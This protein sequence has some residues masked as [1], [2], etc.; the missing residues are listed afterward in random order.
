[1]ENEIRIRS[2]IE[3]SSKS[4]EI[5][6]VDVDCPANELED[7][8]LLTI[9]C[10]WEMCEIE[11]NKVDVWGWTDNTPEDQVEFRVTVQCQPKQVEA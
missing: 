2:A 5:I 9:K 3:S 1:M 7:L 4:G 6:S 11:D 10:N 8:L